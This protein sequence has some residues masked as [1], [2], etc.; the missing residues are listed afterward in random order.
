MRPLQI[1]LS[2]LLLLACYAP[3]HAQ[4]VAASAPSPVMLA[5]AQYLLT[6]SPSSVQD[7]CNRH[8]LSRASTIWTNSSSSVGIYLVSAPSTFYASALETEVED[9]SS[10][11]VFERNQRVNVP[12]LTFA[13]AT[14]AQ[15]TAA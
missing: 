12:E 7:V 14:V 6:T 5:Q 1:I 3:G 15:S 10:V 13:S 8:G 9:D 4:T 11:L 2:A